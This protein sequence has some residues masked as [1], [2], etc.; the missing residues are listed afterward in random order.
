MLVGLVPPR[1]GIAGGLSLPG[2]LDSC[3]DMLAGGLS[4]PSRAVSGGL[5]PLGF[6]AAGFA[7]TLPCISVSISSS[8][9]AKSSNI[10][11]N[12]SRL[13]S[14]VTVS[15]R[16]LLAPRIGA[17][18]LG[19]GATSR[20]GRVLIILSGSRGKVSRRTGISL[21]MVDA[22]SVRTKGLLE[23]M[24]ARGSLRPCRLLRP[25]GEVG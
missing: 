4:F 5:S 6:S 7:M 19:S 1:G 21:L 3:D 12:S 15:W 2:L 14:V 11:S 20:P 17:T 13:E 24:E 25:R 16:R 22:V 23:L 18:S 10:S 8:S 9:P